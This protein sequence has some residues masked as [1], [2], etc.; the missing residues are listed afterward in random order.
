ME[1][2]ES[3][4]VGRGFKL[5]EMDLLLQ[6]VAMKNFTKKKKTKTTLD[7]VD[8]LIRFQ[9]TFYS[10][11]YWIRRFRRKLISKFSIYT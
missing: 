6:Y 5:P 7:K 11:A 8:T 4:S 9:D 10:I 2:W 1:R 3:E